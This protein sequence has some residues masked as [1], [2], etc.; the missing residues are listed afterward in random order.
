MDFCDSIPVVRSI[1]AT[2]SIQI[3]TEIN[4]KRSIYVK[5][6]SILSKIGWIWSKMMTNLTIFD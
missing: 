1:V 3:P 2:I 5:N 4:Q 6:S